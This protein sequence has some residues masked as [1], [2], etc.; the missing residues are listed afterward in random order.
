MLLHKLH[1]Q[2]TVLLG[3][4]QA[5]N[6]SLILDLEKL[7]HVI[8]SLL[9]NHG[10]VYSNKDR[11]PMPTP[12]AK[13]SKISTMNQLH[14]IRGGPS[15][16]CSVSSPPTNQRSNFSP[17]KLQSTPAIPSQVQARHLIT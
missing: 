11:S 5:C 1:L 4:I 16:I 15:A 13:D 17:I 6:G 2:R 12:R 8:G 10:P 14:L 9:S 3:L 7:D